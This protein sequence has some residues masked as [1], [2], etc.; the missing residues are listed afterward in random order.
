MNTTI[1]AS[2]IIKVRV[3]KIIL[4][5]FALA[6]IAAVVGMPAYNSY[7]EKMKFYY[8]E[9]KDGVEVL[10]EAEQPKIEKP[11]FYGLDNKNQPYTIIADVGEQQDKNNLTLSKVYTDIKLN[12]KSFVLMTSD[13]AKIALDKNELDLEG[14]IEI[15]IDADYT[16]NTDKA[17]VFYKTR[18][19][20]GENGVEVN[21]KRGHI[22]ADTFKTSNS[23]DE[24]VFKKNVKTTLYPS[25]NNGKE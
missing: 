15:N 8:G 7:H 18:D 16:I 20:E 5:T 12:D 2:H 21:S 17:K 14:K 4:V 23:Y 3:F 24:I 9:E 19:A 1:V 22:T 10:K 25:E 11:K 13:A 6:L